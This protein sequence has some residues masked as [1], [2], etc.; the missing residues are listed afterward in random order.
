MNQK[1]VEVA[2]FTSECEH[3]KAKIERHSNP[4]C[5]ENKQKSYK[6][7]ELKTYGTEKQ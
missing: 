1:K 7:Y 4:E 3:Y 5:V 6:I 2:I